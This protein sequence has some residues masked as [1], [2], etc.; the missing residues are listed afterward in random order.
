MHFAVDAQNQPAAFGAEGLVA[1]IGHGTLN[2]EVVA[3]RAV[4]HAIGYVVAFADKAPRFFG[5]MGE[6]DL[7]PGRARQ[8]VVTERDGLPFAVGEIFVS[9]DGAVGKSNK[10]FPVGTFDNV[11][12]LRL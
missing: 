10:G 6:H 12:F 9:V 1:Q 8:T 5:I 11:L 3:G 2:H 4:G 7:L